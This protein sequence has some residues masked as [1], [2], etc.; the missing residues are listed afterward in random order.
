MVMKPIISSL[1]R[2]IGN[3][4]RWAKDLIV[5]V[6]AVHRDDEVLKHDEDIGSI[7]PGDMIEFA[8]FIREGKGKQRLSFAT[9]DASPNELV[10][11][12]GCW[13]GPLRYD[14]VSSDTVSG[15][16]RG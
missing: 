1:Q 15:G 4:H 8:P 5:V 6:V 16:G 13:H 12:G 14:L 7:Q 10:A 3:Y 11:V 2:Y 9:S